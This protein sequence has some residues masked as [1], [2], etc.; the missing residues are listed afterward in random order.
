MIRVTVKDY[1]FVDPRF[2]VLG[3]DLRCSAGEAGWRCLQLWSRAIAQQSMRFRPAVL[4]MGL[5]CRE[6]RVA[7]VVERSEIGEVLPNGEI[8]LNL[9]D[10]FGA[11]RVPWHE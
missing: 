5:G 6:Y 4:A 9:R 8:E 11:E 2:D 1:A 3:R 10:V 7:R